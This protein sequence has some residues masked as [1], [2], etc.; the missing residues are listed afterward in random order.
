MEQLKGILY[1]ALPPPHSRDLLPTH[2]RL[3]QRYCG[4]QVLMRRYSLQPEVLSVGHGEVAQHLA[5]YITI[6]CYLN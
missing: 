3:L 1:E 5:V 6:L 2:A 4:I